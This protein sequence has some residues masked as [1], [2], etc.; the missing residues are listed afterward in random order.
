MKNENIRRE[1]KLGKIYVRE[2]L[3]VRRYLHPLNARAK[4][5]KLSVVS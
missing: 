4:L 5:V 2:P 1:L 3:L